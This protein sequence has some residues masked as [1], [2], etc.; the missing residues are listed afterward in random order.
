[1][2]VRNIAWNAGQYIRKLMGWCPNTSSHKVRQYAYLENVG[3]ESSNNAGGEKE[4]MK[5]RKMTLAI[6]GLVL[7]SFALSVYF[8][9][10]VPEQMATHWGPT[11]EVNGYMSKFWGLF[12]MPFMITGIAVLFLVIP[13]VDPRKEN[14][15]KFRKYYDTFIVLTLIFMLVIHCEV[16]LWNTGIKISPNVLVPAGIGILF[17][18]AGFLTEHAQRNWFIGIRTPWTLSSETVWNKT[19]RLGGKLLKL[20]GIISFAGI[21][22]PNLA[23]YFILVPALSFAGFTIVYSYLEYQKELKERTKVH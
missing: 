18:Y 20:A 5:I 13:L 10:Q 1:M 7:F 21:F 23:V 6:I 16:L 8:Y 14:I 2:T 11:G 9:S 4:E 3:L 22:F 12:F 17:Y 19:N 15:E